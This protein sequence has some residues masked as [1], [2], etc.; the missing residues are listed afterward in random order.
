M[1]C[2]REAVEET[3]RRSRTIRHTHHVMKV[4]VKVFLQSEPPCTIRVLPES[5]ATDSSLSSA[6][7]IFTHGQSKQDTATKN[8]IISSCTILA[9]A[10]TCSLSICFVD[11]VWQRHSSL[12]IGPVD[13]AFP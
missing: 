5:P 12:R 3:R 11:E 4:D 9:D 10:G 8:R 1:G 13:Y 6:L 7:P 2:F